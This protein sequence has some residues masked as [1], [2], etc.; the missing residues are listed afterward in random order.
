M[1]NKPHPILEELATQ[2]PESAQTFL[3]IHQCKS[4][5]EINTQAQKEISCLEN[6]QGTLKD[7]QSA[8]SVLQ[9]NG[10]QQWLEDL[11]DDDRLRVYGTLTLIVELSEELAED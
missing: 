5:D 3:N 2:L 7:G 11:E 1:S 6:L 9:E 10:Y 8:R 4:Y